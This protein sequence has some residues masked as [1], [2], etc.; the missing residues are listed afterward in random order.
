MDSSFWFEA[1]N[2]EW[3]IVYTEGSQ[4]IIYTKK[5]VFVIANSV[6]CT[7]RCMPLHVRQASVVRH[8]TDCATLPG[9]LPRSDTEC[10][11]LGYRGLKGNALPLD[12]RG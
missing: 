9:R 6:Q 1:I 11:P 5:I 8:I 10:F 4:V 3:S 2:L 7:P 12:Y